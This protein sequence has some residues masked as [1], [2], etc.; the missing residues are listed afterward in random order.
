MIPYYEL[1]LQKFGLPPVTMCGKLV[2]DSKMFWSPLQSFIRVN[3]DIHKY[4]RKLPF[5]HLTEYDSTTKLCLFFSSG[6]IVAID[7][8]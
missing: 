5:T 2:S 1:V 6:D 3:S 4:F 7:M 8:E